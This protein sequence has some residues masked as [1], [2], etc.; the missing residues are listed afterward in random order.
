MPLSEEKLLAV[1]TI[2]S[3][4]MCADG[5]LS[6]LL[7]KNI[8][9]HVEVKF[10]QYHTPEHVNLNP[11]PGM[12]FCDFSPHPSRYTEFVKAGAIVLDHHK[13]AQHIVEAFG[14][15]GIYSDEVSGAVLAFREVWLK[16]SEYY[17]AKVG[18]STSLQERLFAERIARLVSIRDT[19]QKNDPDWKD[20]CI[21]ARA[22]IFFPEKFWLSAADNRHLFS[23]TK[24][25][26]RWWDERIAIGE[27]LTERAKED[28]ENAI[29]HAYRFTTTTYGTRVVLL[30]N[31]QVTSDAMEV[32]KDEADL[33][34][35]FHYVGVEKSTTVTLAFSTRSNT[36]TNFDCG[37]FC[38]YFDGG[39][40][41]RAAGFSVKFDV[42]TGWHDPYTV[43]RDHLEKYEQQ[44][45][46]L[47]L[48]NS[49]SS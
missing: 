42:K 29:K 49:D 44:A 43:F 37:K 12:L 16:L 40:H 15:D 20:A 31:T 30:P 17:E 33:V 21:L 14:E 32:L 41:T 1:Q 8:L 11:T 23:N 5:I 6:A 7:C 28:V 22:I 18:F 46:I 38:L 45:F 24:Q 2:I 36:N 19:W 27:I 39:G 3:H 13:T 4:K 48:L 25:G 9:P 34:A 47:L 35:G 10:I 26:V